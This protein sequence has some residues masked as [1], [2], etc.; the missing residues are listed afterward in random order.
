MGTS[1]SSSAQADSAGPVDRILSPA[2][3]SS[4]TNA[5]E[6]RAIGLEGVRDDRVLFTGLNF[7]VDPGGVIQIEGP[8][9]C[10]KTTLLRMVCG[11]VLPDEGEIT[12]G[13]EEIQSIRPEYQSSVSYLGHTSGIKEDLTAGENLHV[14]RRLAAISA[15]E[16]V[17]ALEAVG[18]RG[19]ETAMV[20]TLSAGQRRRV[21]LARMLVS[22]APLWVMDEPF[23]ALDPRGVKMVEGMLMNHCQRGGIAIITTHH[24]VDLGDQPVTLLNLADWGEQAC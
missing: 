18:L 16:P 10:G 17:E 20:R 24:P 3:G 9:G 19:F 13:G 14:A 21:A 15:M 2:V 1:E 4:L 6:L 12:W 22:D 8:N 7:A 5:R 23:T 11:F